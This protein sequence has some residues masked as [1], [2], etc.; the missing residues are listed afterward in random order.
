MPRLT[1]VSS[2]PFLFKLEM[3]KGLQTSTGRITF[4]WNGVSSCNT[5]NGFY[6]FLIF[7]LLEFADYL[8]IPLN[9]AIA[10]AMIYSYCFYFYRRFA[11]INKDMAID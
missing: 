5:L 2:A 11:K 7:L 9:N 10:M 8:S 3:K 6:T 4:I 1:I